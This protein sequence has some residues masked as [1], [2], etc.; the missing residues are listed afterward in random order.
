MVHAYAS[1]AY[2]CAIY[3]RWL[4]PKSES[5][6][7]D[8]FFVRLVCDKARVTPVKGT[9][10]PR[11]ELSGFLIFTRLL[12]VVIATMDAQPGQVFTA[13]DSQ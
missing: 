2:A 13:V 6:D 12:K 8:Q 11:S 10:V 4:L 9:T 5:T 7:L 3:I 1:E